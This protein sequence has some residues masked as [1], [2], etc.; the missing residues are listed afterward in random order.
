VKQG[1]SRLVPEVDGELRMLIGVNRPLPAAPDV[2]RTAVWDVRV[3]LRKKR[4]VARLICEE[5]NV[6][7][8]PGR[9]HC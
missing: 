2:K 9:R 7:G 5:K 6:N 3:E 1:V 4:S 8:L